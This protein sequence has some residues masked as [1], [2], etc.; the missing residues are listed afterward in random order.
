MCLIAT[1]THMPYGITVLPATRQKWH[2]YLYPNRL[3]LVLNLAFPEGCKAEL[4]QLTWLHNEVVYA[5]EDSR[6]SKYCR[7]S[8]ESNFVRVMNDTTTTPNRQ[9]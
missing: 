5:P 7:S 1:G 8:A 9:Q 2:F 4:T 6:P 3:K